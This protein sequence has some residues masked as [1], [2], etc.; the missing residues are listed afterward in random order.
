MFNS[1]LK[2]EAGI[3]PEQSLHAAHSYSATFAVLAIIYFMLYVLGSPGL[4][5]V[6]PCR[7]FLALRMHSEGIETAC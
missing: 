3:F 1:D 6:P 7:D 4:V 2:P 5:R